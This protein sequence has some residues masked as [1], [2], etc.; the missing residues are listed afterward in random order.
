MDDELQ[1]KMAEELTSVRWSP[2]GKEWDS[3]GKS[4]DAWQATVSHGFFSK[5]TTTSK[6]VT[7]NGQDSKSIHALK[8][9]CQTICSNLREIIHESHKSVL[10]VSTASCSN[11]G[12]FTSRCTVRLPKIVPNLKFLLAC[13]NAQDQD[14]R[15]FL[16]RWFQ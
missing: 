16:K 13:D 12:N 7:T 5:S 14:S 1:K 6:F 2:P 3:P 10:S 8:A 4:P 9:R 15:N 11:A